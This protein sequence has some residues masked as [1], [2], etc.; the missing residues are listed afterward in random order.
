MSSPL[1]E[2]THIVPFKCYKRGLLQGLKT[3]EYQK[4]KERIDTKKHTEKYT[5]SIATREVA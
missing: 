5:E 1:S 4:I 2:L 3:S